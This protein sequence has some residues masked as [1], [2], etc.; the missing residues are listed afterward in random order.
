MKFVSL[1]RMF[2]D[3]QRASCRIID[4][5][6]ISDEIDLSDKDYKT[7]FPSPV[8]KEYI[9]RTMTQRPYPYSSPTPQ[10]MFV[11]INNKE[12]RVAG[13]FSIDKQFL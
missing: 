8:S 6:A 4:N 2:Y 1:L 7:I 5:E 10:R 3:A 12:F 11:R 9:L 13:A